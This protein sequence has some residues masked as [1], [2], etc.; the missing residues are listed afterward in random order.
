MKRLFIVFALML[1]SSTA[2]EAQRVCGNIDVPFVR[3]NFGLATETS[4][5]S[6]FFDDKG[7]KT[8]T[9][10]VR[11]DQ[12]LTGDRDGNYIC[13]N[14][15]SSTGEGASGWIKSADLAAMSSKPLTA[16]AWIGKWA[17][18]KSNYFTFKTGSKADWIS[19]DGQQEHW[20]EYQ[21]VLTDEAMYAGGFKSEAPLVDGTVGFTQTDNDEFQPYDEKA[22]DKS[23]CAVRFRILS[24]RYLVA[25]DSGY[26][27]GAN[28]TFSGLYVKAK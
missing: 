7:H 14:Y 27:G 15:Q 1:L 26:C 17:A 11:G 18:G 24:E 9:Y 19:V 2:A 10:L 20:A 22:G 28:I 13:A 25:K 12:V 4:A 16:K 21:N 8:K 6:Y 3:G 5:R 23:K